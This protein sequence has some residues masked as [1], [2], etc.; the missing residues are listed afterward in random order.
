VVGSLARRTA[1]KGRSLNWDARSSAECIP[2]KA[3][4]AVSPIASREL[5]EAEAIQ[6][7]RHGDRTVFEFLYRL[8]AGVC[9]RYACAW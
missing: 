6:R 7:A 8:H 9:M 2:K 3:A 4:P 1:E 5:S